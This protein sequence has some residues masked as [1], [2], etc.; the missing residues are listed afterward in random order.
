VHDAVARGYCENPSA[1]AAVGRRA[2]SDESLQAERERHAA[3][4]RQASAEAHVRLPS[5]SEVPAAVAA[6]AAAEGE[7][8]E[9]ESAA[10][11][12]LEARRPVR[13]RSRT[14]GDLQSLPQQK[15]MS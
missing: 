2:Q 9:G 5:V 11:A 3:G 7:T 10:A 13:S 14:G 6:A 12:Q 1:G 8:P 15:S 4:H